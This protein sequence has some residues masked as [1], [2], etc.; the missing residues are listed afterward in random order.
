MKRYLLIICIIA[1]FFGCHK[2]TV[3]RVDNNPP[4]I[5]RFTINGK[6]DSIAGSTAASGS[7]GTIIQRMYYNAAYYYNLT[8]IKSDTGAPHYFISV[9]LYTTTPAAITYTFQYTGI[10][11]FPTLISSGQA[12][13]IKVESSFLNTYYESYQPGDETVVS[14]TSIQ[15]NRA[16]GTY[17]AAK[18]SP[19][20]NCSGCPPSIEITKGEFRNVKIVD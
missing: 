19:G 16:N 9:N 15:D 11:D 12:Q 13:T 14:I 5:F 1:L 4:A 10:A 3:S 2:D 8:A 6:P 18:L 17:S 20:S 7:A